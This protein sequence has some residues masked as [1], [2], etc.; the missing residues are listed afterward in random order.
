MRQT[1][2]SE[3]GL[4]LLEVLISIMITTV[5]VSAV[6]MLIAHAMGLQVLSRDLTIADALAKA[7]IEELRVTDF[8]A[9][10]LALG[11]DLD[12]DVADHNDTL[13]GFKRR[14]VV[15]SG[16]A[17][18][19]DVTIKVVPLELEFPRFGGQFWAWESSHISVFF[20][21][22]HRRQMSE[23]RMPPVR[24]VK[25]FDVVENGQSSLHLAAETAAVDEL[26]L[27]RGKEALT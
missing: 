3:H 24:V 1:D 27:E 18:A 16:P 4:S 22:V 26:A 14:W 5:G 25:S 11:G 7:K 23:R 20:L 17:A 21:V 6:V 10:E 13:E 8:V 15:A 2:H 12:N 9:S 19:L